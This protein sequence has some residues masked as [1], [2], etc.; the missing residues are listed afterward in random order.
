MARKSKTVT[1]KEDNAI[2]Q[3]AATSSRLAVM[4]LSVVRDG[5]N[6]VADFTIEKTSPACKELFGLPARVCGR[7]FLES[8]PGDG[9]LF[10]RLAKVVLTGKPVDFEYA[11]HHGNADLRLNVTVVGLGDV[12]TLTASDITTEKQ[13]ESDLDKAREQVEASN[14]AN[15]AILAALSHEMRTPLNSIIGFAD[16][17]RGEMLGPMANPHYR[18]YAEDICKEGQS[19]LVNLNDMLDRKRFETLKKSGKDYRHILEL[20]P[21]LISVCRDGKIVLI[22]PAGANMLGV[23]PTDVLIGRNFADFVHVDNRALFESGIETLVGEQQRMPIKLVSSDGREV[24]VEIAALPYQEEGQEKAEM[25]IARD[26][27]ERNRST[28]EVATREER[29]RNIMDTVADGIIT[30]DATGIIESFNPAAEKIFGYSTGEIVGKKVNTLMPEPHAGQ[31]DTYLENYLKTG[32]AKIIGSGRE[33]EGLNKNG[34]PIP[35]EISITEHRSGTRQLFIGVVR[36]ITE[37]KQSEERLRHLA[38]RDPLTGLPNRYLFRERLEGAV[39]RADREHLKTAVLFVD[40]D[41]FK[42]INDTLGQQMG[43]KVLQAAGDRLLKC[44]RDGDTVAHLGGD[45][46]T[47]ILDG[48]RNKSEAKTIAHRMLD[49][50][51]RP[52]AIEGKE[53][54]TSG[55]I[56]V[57]YYPDNAD[58]ISDLLKNVDTA[59]HHAKKLGRNNLQFYTAE[60]SANVLRRMEIETGLR[61][62]LERDEF[63]LYYQA[64]VDLET[65]NIVGAEALLRWSAK[66]LG[67]VSPDEF[68]PVAEETG[69]IVPIGEWVLRHACIQGVSWIKE[70]LPDIHLAVNLSA[71]QFKQKNLIDRISGILSETGMN[72]DNLELEMTESMLMENAEETIQVFRSLK[73]MGL[74]LS[75]DDFGTGYS[76]LSYLTRFPIDALKI[77]RSF[78]TNLPDDRDAVAIAKAIVSMA[79]NL[80][81][82]IIA[83]GIETEGQEVFLHALGCSQGQGYLFSKPVPADEFAR[84]IGGGAR[85]VAFTPKASNV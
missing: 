21:D 80:K 11:P 32:E 34:T 49:S 71:Y 50:I 72:T 27:T 67:G 4:L 75:I 69:L 17:M 74:S 45:E 8:M 24:E 5:D 51:S 81:L 76:S 57:V 39:A 23:W 35:L 79:K 40:L 31:H 73:D 33:A 13:R 52:F 46:F 63:E 64:K 59:I 68:I 15:L 19:M 36:D 44:V 22:N 41:N 3:G 26:V 54:Y 58:N 83:E 1:P 84:L 82:K 42:S 29:L 25:L 7:K 70:G 62:A 2:D 55:S 53:I 18:E 85:V 38:T 14:Q 30:I 20:A 48:I 77:D 6:A 37:R 12:I 47:I 43:D 60:L 10:N 61:R 28:R 9:N 65:R 16:M 78:V 66:D 56:G